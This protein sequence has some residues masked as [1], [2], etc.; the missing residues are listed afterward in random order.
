MNNSFLNMLVLYC[1]HKIAGERTIYSILHLLNGKKSS[2]TIQDAHLFQLTPLFNTFSSLGRSGLENLVIMLEEEGSVERYGE[3]SY[4]VTLAGMERLN[5]F[6]GNHPFPLGLNG[7]K[8]HR[9]SELFWERLTLAVQVISHLTNR[10]SK[11]IPIQ[12]KKEIH[13]WLKGFLHHSRLS[14]DELGAEIYRELVEC[15][16]SNEELNP[17]ILV[18]RLTGHKNIGLTSSQAA[19]KL[20][21]DHDDYHIQFLAI[22]HY[23]LET[24]QAKPSE[25]PLLSELI[26]DQNDTAPLTQSTK[27]TFSF[28]EKGYQVEEIARIR[29]LKKST[30]EDHIVEI[31]L[32]INSFDIAPFVNMEKQN[33]IIRAAKSITSKQLKHIR[34]FVPD[35]DYFEIRLVLAKAGDES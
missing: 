32:N 17:S 25:F 8:F 27:K 31:A 22:L 4:Q 13:H 15:L 6:F 28:L 1:L 2:Q 30:I 20:K 26:A 34:Q 19:D 16:E 3:Q 33:L 35:A 11:Y 23:M 24:V 9:L 12:R 29:K 7:W 10:D 14:R 18:I 21:M 5:A